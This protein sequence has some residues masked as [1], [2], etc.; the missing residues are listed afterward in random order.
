MESRI[1]N[2]L[3]N[4]IS[5]KEISEI[6]RDLN[7]LDSNGETF[8]TMITKSKY[9]DVRLYRLL[10]QS[11]AD[12]NIRNMNGWTALGILCERSINDNQF[13][14][15]ELLLSYK[16]DLTLLYTYND[17]FTP[18][19]ASYFIAMGYN[20]K[21]LDLII[22]YGGIPEGKILQRLLIYEHD[23]KNIVQV[24]Q[25]IALLLRYGVDPNIR[26]DKGES[27]MDLIMNY[28]HGDDSLIN[29]IL[30]HGFR[31]DPSFCK[32]IDYEIKQSD[33]QI[34]KLD[35]SRKELN[36]KRRKYNTYHDIIHG[37][38][39]KQFD[40]IVKEVV[41]KANERLFAPGSMHCCITEC[42]WH[43]NQYD[44]MREKHPDIMELFHIT[45]ES[46]FR[47]RI[48]EHARSS[49]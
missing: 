36:A 16:S 41:I 30:N 44:L 40:L 38:V 9:P 23:T 32:K 24:H 14:L 37:A 10:L 20:P 34:R 3:L 27:C 43:L 11:G 4:L 48:S 31:P 29:L 22:Q 19:S 2:F 47:N 42:Y 46:E 28:Y 35:E 6:N 33:D 1:I 12:P 15:I 5:P 8:L 39:K 18:V 7:E 26:S 49:V 25:I 21:S 17:N 13:E 45:N